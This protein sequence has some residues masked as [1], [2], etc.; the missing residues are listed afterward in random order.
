LLLKSYASP[1]IRARTKT[2]ILEQQRVAA[3]SAL[4]SCFCYGLHICLPGGASNCAKDSARQ[5]GNDRSGNH[6][7][8]RVRRSLPVFPDQRT[9]SESVGTSQRCQQAT[10]LT[11][12]PGPGHCGSCTIRSTPASFGF[13]CDRSKLRDFPAIAG[14]LFKLGLWQKVAREIKRIG[15]HRRDHGARDDC[16]DKR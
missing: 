12:R 1:N 8:L 15:D 11:S 2:F 4:S 9:F 16:C 7:L 14:R 10:C 3:R 13:S 5:P 6:V